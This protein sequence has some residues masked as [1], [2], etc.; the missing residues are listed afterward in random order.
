MPTLKTLPVSCVFKCI[1]I[2]GL[3]Q[4]DVDSQREENYMPWSISLLRT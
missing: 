3:F 1:N 2:H 4:D